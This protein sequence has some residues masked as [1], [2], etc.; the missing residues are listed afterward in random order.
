FSFSAQTFLF[1]F[2]H[3]L[4]YYFVLFFCSHND[5]L[6]CCLLEGAP[7]D[8]SGFRT[9][10]LLCVCSPCALPKCAFKEGKVLAIQVFKLSSVIALFP[11]AALYMAIASS[12]DV[13]ADHRPTSAH[14]P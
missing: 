14:M 1:I 2:L 12:C 11:C 6:F 4:A 7:I 5:Y 10:L 13:I 9:R 3:V 8:G